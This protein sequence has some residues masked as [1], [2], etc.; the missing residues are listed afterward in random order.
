MASFA[1][2][3]ETPP[4]HPLSP[5]HAFA[6]ASCTLTAFISMKTRALS[7]SHKPPTR[8]GYRLDPRKPNSPLVRRSSRKRRTSRDDSAWGC[9]LGTVVVLS[10]TAAGFVA[11]A[12]A[13]AAT[14]F[15]VAGPGGAAIGFFA[16]ISTGTAAGMKAGQTLS[17]RLNA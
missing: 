11:G 7:L 3:I 4:A 12:G 6:F 10:T 9:V 1:N 8:R 15:A 17:R 13:G 16:G 2:Q 5:F 14:G